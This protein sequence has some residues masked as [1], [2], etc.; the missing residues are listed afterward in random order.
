MVVHVSV[1][2]GGRELAGIAQAHE[3][4]AAA[5]RRIAATVPGE[6]VPADLSGDP[7]RFVVTPDTTVGLRPMT[8]GD[9]PDMVRWRSSAHIH[10]W[11]PG[12]TAHI[13]E[14]Y[15]P[16]IDGRGATRLWI[17]E[18]NGRS[19]GF[20]QDYL[21]AD[22]PQYAV[23]TP[24][25]DAVGVDYLIGEEKFTGRGSGTLMVWAWMLSARRRYPESRTFFAAPD[26]RN[27]ASLRVLD[28]V[29]F[30]QGLWFDEPQSDGGVSTV[31]GC[32]LDVATV[33]G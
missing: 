5:A 18:L 8:R 30:T 14:Q 2:H 24:A 9:L 6:P 16:A 25:P 21:I 31:V 3:S 19:V 17:A 22:H 12:D 1:A 32:S 23:P 27:G 11:W 29:G 10:Q 33:L 15:L 7:K 4:W 26:H 13:E 20:I 28:K